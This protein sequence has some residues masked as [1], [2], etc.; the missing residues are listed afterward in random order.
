MSLMFS[1]K[2][3]SSLKL[4]RHVIYSDGHSY[5]YQVIESKGKDT[6]LG[7]Y[8]S[9]DDAIRVSVLVRISL[10]VFYRY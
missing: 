5:M 3:C 9:S 10:R 8:S 2:C 4:F 1:W 7:D 6:S